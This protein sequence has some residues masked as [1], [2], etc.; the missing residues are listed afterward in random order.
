MALMR[1]KPIGHDP[2]RLAFKFTML[3]EGKVVPCKISKA[4]MD[5]LGSTVATANGGRHSQ[6]SV[7]REKPARLSVT[8]SG[9][10][11]FIL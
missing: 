1:D 11:H 4:A 3:N 9:S 6:F 7:L 8:V 2:D 10:R 5:E